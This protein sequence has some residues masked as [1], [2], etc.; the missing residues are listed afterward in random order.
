MEAV[1]WRYRYIKEQDKE[2]VV[3]LENASVNCLRV[4]LFH[5]SG[6]KKRKKQT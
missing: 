6:E 2:F 5:L 1:V 4:Q 3:E